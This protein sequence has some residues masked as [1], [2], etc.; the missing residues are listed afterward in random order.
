MV[1]S[2]FLA[3]EENFE[4]KIKTVFIFLLQLFLTVFKVFIVAQWGITYFLI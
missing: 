1:F 4:F 2:E 3:L